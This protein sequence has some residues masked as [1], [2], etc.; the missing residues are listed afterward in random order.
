MRGEAL[1]T[2][3]PGDFAAL[4]DP[5]GH[6]AD[7]EHKPARAMSPELIA[8]NSLNADEAMTP[9]KAILLSIPLYLWNFAPHPFRP[10]DPHAS[11]IKWI[12]DLAMWGFL[13]ILEMVG[14]MIKPIALCLRLFGNMVAGH[15]L[16]AVLIG[17]ILIV[18]G[19]AMRGVIAAPISLLD[20]GIQMLEIF[21]AFLQA[22][23][24]VFL[25]TL[26]IASAVAPEH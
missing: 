12:P 15:V 14:A 11:W 5:S 25:T 26:F 13:L 4:G 22:Y 17:L 10:A 24:F 9:L 1:A 2:D 18:P 21:V 7:G 6:Y 23:I 8:L 20:L 3:V 16:L 19:V